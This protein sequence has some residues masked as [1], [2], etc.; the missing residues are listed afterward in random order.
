MR[1]IPKSEHP[2]ANIDRREPVKDMILIFLA[3]IV[4]AIGIVLLVAM[5]LQMILHNISLESEQRWFS[6][7]GNIVDSKEIKNPEILEIFNKVGVED[8]NGKVKI[9]LQCSKELNAFAIPGGSIVLTSEL[10]KNIN[11]EEG[12]VFV[13]GHEIGHIKNR[14][15]VVGFARSAALFIADIFLNFRQWPG[16]NIL[17]NLF[18]LAYSRNQEAAADQVALRKMKSIYGDIDGGDEFFLLLKKKKL[19]PVPE[20]LWFLSSHPMTEERLQNFENANKD[21]LSHRQLH[22]KRKEFDAALC[23]SGCEM[24]AC[25]KNY[26][27]GPKSLINPSGPSSLAQTQAK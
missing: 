17:Q 4:A 13:I 27:N 21:F 9:K 11:T 26:Q 16:A 22:N 1:Y 2:T 25:T 8:F 7:M 5:I 20:G 19:S 6:W 3:T 24:S 15:H 14:D 10:L 23:E 12:M 18:L